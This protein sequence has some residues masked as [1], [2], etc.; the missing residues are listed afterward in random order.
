MGK[1]H[2]FANFCS[3]WLLW[4]CHQSAI[5]WYQPKEYNIVKLSISCCKGSIPNY[6]TYT[7][8]YRTVFFLVPNYHL[9]S[10]WKKPLPPR[11]TKLTPPDFQR[12]RAFCCPFWDLQDLHPHCEGHHIGGRFFKLDNCLSVVIIPSPST[13]FQR[14]SWFYHM[15]PTPKT[16]TICWI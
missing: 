6:P 2:L 16:L 13:P 1:G 10:G 11:K 14:Q 12:L 5:R 3:G 9:Q 7:Y 15:F 8:Q 4:D